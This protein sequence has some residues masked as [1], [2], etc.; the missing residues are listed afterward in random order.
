MCTI[1][2]RDLLVFQAHGGRSFASPHGASVLIRTKTLTWVDQVQKLKRSH[3]FAVLLTIAFSEIDNTPFRALVEAPIGQGGGG[4]MHDRP[5]MGD[6][7][8][9]NGL[10]DGIYAR[11]ARSTFQYDNVTV[12]EGFPL[13]RL[14]GKSS[15]EARTKERDE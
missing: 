14:A 9:G 3:C 11:H 6:I 8:A 2:R 13:A 1:K 5:P 7:R 12:L 15:S 4:S 10:R